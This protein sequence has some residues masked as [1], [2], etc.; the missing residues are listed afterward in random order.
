MPQ[1]PAPDSRLNPLP[2]PRN[3]E[4]LKPYSACRLDREFCELYRTGIESTR[5]ADHPWR[6]GRF[7]QM[8]Q[9]LRLTEGLPG[10]TCEA[11]CFRGLAS[12]LIC[13][14]R[15]KAEPG[16]DGSG[17]W[18]VDSFE[19][20]SPPVAE[21]GDFA[22]RRYA[23]K[24]FTKTS[25][26]HVRKA[27]QDFPGVRI[28]KGWIPEVFDRLP[29]Q[30]YRF[31]HV[32]VDIYAPTLACLEYFFPRLVPGGILVCDDYGPWPEGEWTGCGTAVR[33]FCQREAISFAALETGNAVLVRRG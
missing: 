4:E 2:G 22:A 15:R 9:M 24:A 25:V 28:E 11:G 7:F 8:V 14:Y 23:E 30:R 31:V 3:L 5:M 33:E 26:E 32:D 1:S 17:H 6:D 19:G 12:W 29:D 27:L 10:A 20:L 18:M 16:F 13:Q 21:D